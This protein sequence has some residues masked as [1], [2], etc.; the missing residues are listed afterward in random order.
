MKSASVN[1]QILG[2]NPVLQKLHAYAKSHEIQ[3]YLVGGS[4]RDLLLNRL[5]TDFDFTMESDAIQFAKL[6]ADSINAPFVP[7]EEHPPT[8]RVI[9]KTQQPTEAELDLDFAQ[10]RAD[11][12]LKDLS[13]RDL[14]INAMAIPFDS[15]MESDQP[16]VID[17]CNGKTDLE[18]RQLRFPSEQVIIDDPLRLMRI[19]RI[20]AQLDFQIPQ[21]SIKLVKEHTHL[22]PKVSKERVRDELFKLL[23]T[24][25]SRC[26]LQQISKVGLLDYVIPSIKQDSCSWKALKK[27]EDNPIPE[28]LFKY[29]TEIYT[30]L[31]T[32]LGLYASRRSLIKLCIL[33]QRNLGEIG[34]QLRLSRKSVQ[35]LKCLIVKQQQL[36]EGGMTHKEM[37]NF[38]RYSGS[39]WLGVLLYSVVL[40]PMPPQ[41]QM[42]IAD[43]YYLHL[44]PILKQ[45]RLI[46]GEELKNKFQL[47]EGKEIGRL[48]K[49]IEERQHYGEIQTRG[50]AF[51]VV[52]ELIRTQNN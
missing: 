50:E 40:Y 1:T 4:V 42:D 7:L 41:V 44:L 30:Y 46:S 19:Y 20:S 2:D 14:T 5:I 35:Y 45:G 12:L 37:V 32:E 15:L 22:L 13:L 48:L 23:N 31:N 38:L 28:S 33:L 36:T 8:A 51:A 18:Q 43:T 39:D 6:F 3:L 17:P 27:F 49:Q 47:K 9:V 21:E 11:T 24:N 26:Y 34:K 25:T 10:Y 16:E 52:E 29:Q